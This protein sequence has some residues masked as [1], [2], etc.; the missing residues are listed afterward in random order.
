MFQ[1]DWVGTGRK[2]VFVFHLFFFALLNYLYCIYSNCNC[3]QDVVVSQSL[4]Y[5]ITTKEGEGV[6][7]EVFA[8]R[9]IKTFSRGILVL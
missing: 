3:S 5:I 6:K 1:L 4:V 7:G 8:M 2:S 9:T